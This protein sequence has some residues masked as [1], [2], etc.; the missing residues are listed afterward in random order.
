[1]L[2]Q[3]VFGSHGYIYW[4]LAIVIIGAIGYVP[5]LR[6]ISYGLLALVVIVLF[7]SQGSFF[8]KFNQALAQIG[9]SAQGSTTTPSQTPGS[10][11]T[12]FNST[13]VIPSL[14]SPSITQAP[15]TVPLTTE[16]PQ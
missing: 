13:N 7:L 15:T 1:M 11:V 8:Q 5:R 2:K 10:P 6:P 16:I 4:F 12:L 3:D 9:P 14:T